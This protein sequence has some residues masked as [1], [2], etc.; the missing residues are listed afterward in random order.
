MRFWIRLVV[1]ILIGLAILLVI[2]LVFGVWFGIRTAHGRD[3]GQW[4]NA[5]PAIS[6]WF[7]SLQQPDVEASCCGEADAYWAD[8]FDSN[9]DG[10]YIAIIT[11]ER[12]DTALVRRHIP[13]GTRITIPKEKVKWDQGNPTGH[14]VVFVASTDYDANTPQGFWVYCYVPPGGA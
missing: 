5:D 9:K 1:D 7:K 3:L 13:V 11:D 8:G 12:D 10:N 4:G 2:G 14:G 6:R